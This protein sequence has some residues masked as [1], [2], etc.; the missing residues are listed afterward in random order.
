M[1]TTTIFHLARHGQTQWNIE[2]R[3]QGQLDS[4]LT[5]Q[6]EQ[7]ARQ[8]ARQCHSLQVTQVLTSSLGRAQ[9]TATL[10]AQQLQTPVHI[11]KGIE[12]RNFGSWEGKSTPQVV[13]HPDYVE[14]TSQ[15]TDCKPEGGES[16]Q[17]LLNRFEDALKQQFTAQPSDNYLIITHGDVMRCFMTKF[18]QS[19]HV[20]TGFDYKNGQLISLCYD[21]QSGQFL[22]L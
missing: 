7:Q 8:L 22:P 21:H 2:Q 17:Q 5:T 12:E 11:L 14:I 6:G 1:T 15:V 10:C 3:I 16:A 18:Q 13:G 19:D 20:S 9:Q 4:P